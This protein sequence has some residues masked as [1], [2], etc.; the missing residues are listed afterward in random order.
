[1]SSRR[2]AGDGDAFDVLPDRGK[3]VV[4]DDTYDAVYT[5]HET[6]FMFRAG[7][8]FLWFRIVSPG[9]QF[10]VEVYRAYNV[11]Q[12]F[13]PYGKGGK[14]KPAARC[15][16]VLD[17]YRLFEVKRRLDRFTLS[18]LKGKVWVIRTRSVSKDWSQR[19]VPEFLRYSVVSEIVEAKTG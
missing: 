15:D 6:G 1:V 2:G 7:K 8:V 17:L 4:P 3:P 19:D 13:R 16:L 5:G 11:R 9:N 12:V 14:F 18:D 10:G